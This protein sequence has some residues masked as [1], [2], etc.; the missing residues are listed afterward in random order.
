MARRSQPTPPPSEPPA[1]RV[2]RSEAAAR[3]K[4]QI[5]EGETLL[6]ANP[7]TRPELDELKEKR[8]LWSDYNRELLIQLFT[9]TAIANEYST[10]VGGILRMNPDFATLVKEYRDG[11]QRRLTRLKS[12]LRRLELFP[13]PECEAPQQ[14]R[15]TPNGGNGIFLVHGQNNEAKQEVARFLERLNLGVTILHEQAD[16]GR[17]IIEKFED[18]ASV[19]YAIILL[20]ADDIGGRRTSPNDLKSRARQNVILEMGY[21]LGRVGRTHVCALL[22]DGVEVPSD[23][24]G[25]L[26]V[27]LDPGG[28]WK[29]RLATEMK[30]AGIAIDLNQVRL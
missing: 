6:A 9:S 15:Q 22:E 21:F 30:A 19:G 14:Q 12:V 8:K 5:D 16:R 10:A 27:P 26:Y 24:S 7:L 11:V 23:L 3:I 18:H 29:L 25:V 28:A 4:T 2:P 1:L 17:T 13:A 20:T